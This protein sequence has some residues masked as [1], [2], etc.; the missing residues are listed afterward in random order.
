M[1]RRGV[2]QQPASIKCGATTVRGTRCKAPRTRRDND[3]RCIWHT[4]NERLRKKIQRARVQGG[5]H[6]RKKAY[7]RAHLKRRAEKFLEQ[8]PSLWDDNE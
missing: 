4:T 1:P 8:H 3:G 6:K 2:Y 5:R 7:T